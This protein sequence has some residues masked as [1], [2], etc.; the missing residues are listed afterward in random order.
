MKNEIICL[1]RLTLAHGLGR[2]KI[3]KLLEQFGTAEKATEAGWSAKTQKFFDKWTVKNEKEDLES[4]ERAGV[5]LISYLDP[6]YPQN[7]LTIPNFP[8]LLYVKGTL[9]TQDQNSLA[10]IGTRN[11]T[12]YG[13]QTAH[14]LAADTAY[15]GVTIVSGLARGIDT[16]A[17]MGALKGG[18]RTLAILGSGL[19]N[20]YPQENLELAR[21]ITH[22]GAVISEYPMDTSPA[23]GLFPQRNRIV[24]G[25]AQG[26]CLIESP[27]KGGGMLTM[28]IA[29]KQ[30][31]MLFALPG[32]IDWPN[33]EGNHALIK[34]RKALLVENAQDLL[35]NFQDLKKQ[36][37]KHAP[38]P[39]LSTVE[40][41][42]L[43]KLPSQEKSIE[44]L[45]LL[46]QLPI[47]QL[48]VLLTRLVLKKV[49]K[50]FPGKIYK[51]TYG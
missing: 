3:W 50:E 21:Q 46:T 40:H 13:R 19:S 27:L 33:F 47:M 45:V 4:V 39:H 34:K 23:K 1:H 14:Q 43:Q 37:L 12:L 28:E 7:L 41:A 5:Q 16:A 48:N 36:D 32:R 38:T 49:V 20:P 10:L 31:K 25:I 6:S 2:Q 11:A 24:S 22:S 51:K 44:E 8:L 26:V 17:H 18:G 29:E 35:Q 15:G 30:K 9:H 42:F